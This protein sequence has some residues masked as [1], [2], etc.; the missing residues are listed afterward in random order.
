MR[1]T[2]KELMI[3]ME[4]LSNSDMDFDIDVSININKKKTEDNQTL[5][6][7]TI[8]NAKECIDTFKYL[9]DS[10]DDILHTMDRHEDD[11]IEPEYEYEDAE[12]DEY[13]DDTSEDYDEYDEYLEEKYK[14]EDGDISEDNQDSGDIDDD[15]PEILI[16]IADRLIDFTPKTDIGDF[17]I[18]LDSI[19]NMDGNPIKISNDGKVTI[20]DHVYGTPI[21]NMFL[22]YY[23]M[24]VKVV[25]DT[26]LKII[27]MYGEFRNSIYDILKYQLCVDELADFD[28]GLQYFITD[29]P[30]FNEC[31]NEVVQKALNYVTKLT[32]TQE[33]YE[34]YKSGIENIKSSIRILSSLQRA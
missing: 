9:R 13:W 5:V 20:S 8:K 1:C 10:I 27:D 30:R 14:Y 24:M 34:S 11:N 4:V 28:N 17:K 12:Y 6:S 21:K 3:L 32:H 29:D 26:Y 18:I 23:H 22:D 31:G 16:E 19:N 2:K 15:V 7:N 25:F 33:C